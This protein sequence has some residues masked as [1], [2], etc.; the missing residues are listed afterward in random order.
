VVYVNI[1]ENIVSTIN[2]IVSGE[3]VITTTTT[4]TTTE[5][6]TTT[7]PPETTTQTTTETTTETT[8]Q[9][10]TKAATTEKQTETTTQSSALPDGVSEDKVMR[11]N[12]EIFYLGQSADSLPAYERVD[13]GFEGCDWYIYNSDYSHYTQVAVVDGV[14][15][16]IY[17]M[18]NDFRYK[19]LYY[20]A[21]ASQYNLTMDNYYLYY[22][23]ERDT[24][25]GVQSI[26]Y[27]DE[28]DG[29][30]MYGMM[31]KSTKWRPEDIPEFGWLEESE[32]EERLEGMRKEIADITNAYRDQNNLPVLR[33][34]NAKLNNIA[35]AH[36]ADMAEN[37]YFSH[38]SL[39]GT[40]F[41]DR[42]LNAVGSFRA[43]GENIQSGELNAMGAVNG[44]INSTRHRTNLVSSSYGYLGIG[45][46]CNPDSSDETY[47]VQDFLG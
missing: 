17:T 7:A 31:L 6:T 19:E 22:V 13:I 41:N 15:Q 33:T 1:A 26:V 34:S 24:K 45:F 20:D 10:T 8:T 39:D 38:N 32:Q 44:W 40:P 28:N 42:I 9:A 2:S 30:R 36:A 3:L 23:Y 46:A 18:S 25:A 16:A 21:D 43:A 29:N 35:Q 4:E 27:Y 47:F 11:I 12:G 14:V 5:T 37:N